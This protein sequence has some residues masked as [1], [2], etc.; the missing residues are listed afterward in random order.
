[1]TASEV[2]KDLNISQ[3]SISR[4]CTLL[5]YHGYSDF[6]RHLKEYVRQEITT[7]ERLKYI[8][9]DEGIIDII[10]S[11]KTNADELKYIINQKSYK[12]LVKKIINAKN[13][14]LLSARMSATL[15]PYI[16]YILNK[17]RG[18]I[19]CVTPGTSLWDSINLLNPKETQIIT[20]IFPRYPNIL[21]NKL[22][23]LGKKG[24]SVAAITD[25]MFSP[26]INFANPIIIVPITNISIFDV[27]STPMLF[28]NLLLRDVAKGIKEIDE[29]FKEIDEYEQKNNIYFTED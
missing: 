8:N 10:N 19:T 13:L 27:Y 6:L 16:F 7:P 18:G 4:F 5:G 21:I 15:L 25:R 2:A 24:F 1:M 3:A 17:I 9:N 20:I 22:D 26:V 29:R 28:F 11:E 12:E 14:V 23:E